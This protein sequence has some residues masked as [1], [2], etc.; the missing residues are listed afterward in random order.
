MPTSIPTFSKLNSH[1]YNS[2]VGEM[3]AYLRSQNAWMPISMPS[4][5]PEL[6]DKPTSDEK[7]EYREWQKEANA[8]SGLIY[9]MVE[10]DQ[11]IHL[12]DLKDHPD[13]MWDALKQIHMQQRPGTCFNAYDD[14]FSIRK[15]EE[16][17]LQTLINRVE[18]G[19]KRI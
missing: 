2:W 13:K 1:N 16:E 14:L 11:R 10:D 19:M 3:E 12:N 7:K 15:K 5:A 6:S 8:A 18:T 17:N 9:L 4:L